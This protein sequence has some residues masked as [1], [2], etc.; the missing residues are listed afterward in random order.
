MPHVRSRMLSVH[1][2]VAIHANLVPELSAQQLPE[3]DAPGLACNVPKRN[4]NAGNAAA[5]AGV[6]AKLFYSS[7]QLV[8]I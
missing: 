5:L 4:F 1:V 8:N 7:E 2:G 3:R 6:A